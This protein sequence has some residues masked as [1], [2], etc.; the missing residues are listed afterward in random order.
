MTPETQVREIYRTLFST[1]GPQHWW[2]A[3]SRF[4]VIV[5][6]YL[7]QNTSWKNVEYAIANLRC[8]H[9]LSIQS[10]REISIVS[11]EKLIRPAGF[12][13]QK[14]QR[15]KNFVSYLDRNYRGS[16]D[17]MFTQPTEKLRQEL[18]GLNGVGPETA[19][20]ILL[21]AGKHPVFV[22][23]AYTR[24]IL[25]RHGILPMGTRYEDI[26]TFFERALARVAIDDSWNLSDQTKDLNEKFLPVSKKP[27][28][29][30]EDTIST[31]VL[32]EMHALVVQV[33]KDCCLSKRAKC[34]VCPL[35][36]FL[37]TSS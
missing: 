27:I 31:Q 12:Y 19:D 8:Q 24:R 37:V 23:D 2:P 3:K 14:A 36:G 16:L 17:R 25:D 26:R 32:N 30:S 7:T 15:L 28:A 21:Y 18:L 13:R 20:S 10:I 29:T 5:G 4:E 9:V 6:A 1:Y 11:L 33:G 35:R 22:V 34:D